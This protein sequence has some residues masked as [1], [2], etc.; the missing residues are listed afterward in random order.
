MMKYIAVLDLGTTGVRVLVAKITESGATHII[1]KASVACRGVRKFR[2]ENSTE[3]TEAIRKVIRRIREQTDIIVKSVYVGL[4]GS[5]V[6]YIKNTAS[7]DIDG[8]DSTVTGLHIATLLDKVESVELYENEFLVGAV[9]MR[10]MIDNNVPTASPLGMQARSL[11]VDAQ[12]LTADLDFVNE[13]SECIKSAGLEI[14]GF[15]PLS[16]AMRG[17]LPEGGESDQSTLLID[18]GGT[19]TEFCVYFKKTVYFASAIPVGGDNITNDVA[20]V[21]NIRREEADGLKRDYPIADADLVTNNVDVAIFSLSSNQQELIKVH[22]IVEIMQ[23]RIEDI[24]TIIRDKLDSE[25]I[26]TNLID[27]VIFAG[28]GIMG[29]SG[30]SEVCRRVLGTTQ[31]NVDFSR[32]TGMKAIYTYASGMVMYVSSMLPY[33]M[34]QSAIEK[35]QA[36]PEPEKNSSKGALA[37]LQGRLKDFIDRLRD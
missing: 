33:G 20:Q 1:A 11:R 15:I 34:K 10:Y 17:L 35:I 30:L 2:V 12:V 32:Y 28:D 22:D 7:V 3:V 23:A 6:G 16:V 5:Y 14:D 13:L 37:S 27:R 24:L 18:V 29:F 8:E 36:Q 31:I 25:D 26:Q 19:E 9:P 4:F 21:L